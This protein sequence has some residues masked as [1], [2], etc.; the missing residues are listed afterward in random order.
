MCLFG[1]V[2][3]GIMRLNIYGKIVWSCWREI[4]DHFPHV[5]LDEFVV[6]PNHVHGILWIVDNVGARHG[7]PLPNGGTVPNHERF[8][9][10]VPGSIPTII[11]SFK[12]AVTKQINGKRGTPGARVWQRNYYEH[13]I[14]DESSLN[15]IREYI[16]MNP[17]RWAMD[18][19]NPQRTEADDYANWQGGVRVTFA[20]DP[21]TP[22]RL[23][24][25]G[26]NERQIKVIAVL[27]K[28]ESVSIGELRRLFPNISV[29]TMQRDL[30]ALMK[31]GLL[32]A[33]G[34]KKGRRYTLAR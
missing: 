6:M 17:L 27:R 11:R 18:R 33:S 28:T 16:T 26:L 30:Q 21:Y 13:I 20:K 15:R 32:K 12:S 34:E 8:G 24:K 5:E 4:P 31:K 9:K 25:L 1:H 7:V 14:R 2:T 10:P 22:E 19:E 29:K 23:R 3:D